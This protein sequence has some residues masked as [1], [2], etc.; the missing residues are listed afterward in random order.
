MQGE[1]SVEG[2]ALL[3]VF[4]LGVHLGQLDGARPVLLPLV[5]PEAVLRRV[6]VDVRPVGLNEIKKI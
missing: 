1:P 5:P 6:G 3:E 4:E 2:D